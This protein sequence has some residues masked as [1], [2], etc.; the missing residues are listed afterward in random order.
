MENSEGHLK[1]VDPYDHVVSNPNIYLPEGKPDPI[2]LAGDVAEAALLLG[3]SRTE[4]RRLGPWM[5]VSADRDWTA[6]DERDVFEGLV[7]FPEAGDNACRPE[8]IICVFASA[9]VFRRHGEP[10]RFLKDEDQGRGIVPELGSKWSCC[11]AF[12]MRIDVGST[13]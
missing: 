11:L 8:F 3:A 4:I 13:G 5:V 10:A 12:Q 7:P 2:V 6:A 1:V 9:L